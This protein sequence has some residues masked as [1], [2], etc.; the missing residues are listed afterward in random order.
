MTDSPRCFLPDDLGLRGK[1]RPLRNRIREISEGLLTNGATTLRELSDEAILEA[2]TATVQSYK[3]PRSPERL[4]LDPH[5]CK[6]SRLSPGCLQASLAALLAGFTDKSTNRLLE[7]A[8]RFH[9]RNP[10]L[11]FLGSTIPGRRSQVRQRFRHHRKLS[12]ST[13]PPAGTGARFWSWG[14][15]FCTCWCTRRIESRNCSR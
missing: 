14:A 3:D 10:A 8:V 2:W 5:L 4:R 11:V 1:G 9:P 12:E 13:G 7:R 15:S 6:A